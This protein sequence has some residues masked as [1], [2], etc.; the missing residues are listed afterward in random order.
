MEFSR[1]RRLLWGILVRSEYRKAITNKGSRDARSF[2]VAGGLL[3]YRTEFDGS[4]TGYLLWF[5]I[6]VRAPDPGV[7]VGEPLENK[8]PPAEKESAP[9]SDT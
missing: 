7:I 1:T 5:P 4:Q 3:G 2:L 6:P 8:S 9:R